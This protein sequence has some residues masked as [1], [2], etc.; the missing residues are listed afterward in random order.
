MAAN[1]ALGSV[2]KLNS[3]I[4][5]GPVKKIQFND[6]GEVEYLVAWTDMDGVSQERWFVESVLAAA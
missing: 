3:V 4:P 2:V 5:E 6:A 1:F